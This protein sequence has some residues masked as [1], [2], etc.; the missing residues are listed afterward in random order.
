[1]RTKLFIDSASA[2][3]VL[4]IAAIGFDWGRRLETEQ[5]SAMIEEAPDPAQ[6]GRYVRIGLFEASPDNT[7]HRIAALGQAEV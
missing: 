5:E 4:V 2:I 3:V 7:I 6:S 1:M